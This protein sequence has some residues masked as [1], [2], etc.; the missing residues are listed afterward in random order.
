[1][2]T[3]LAHT[4]LLRAACRSGQHH[5][6]SRVGRC[7]WGEYCCTFVYTLGCHFRKH[8]RRRPTR[9]HGTRSRATAV[10][11]PLQYSFIHL[12]LHNHDADDEGIHRRLFLVPQC[13][14][15]LMTW[16]QH[17]VVEIGIGVQGSLTAS[18]SLSLRRGGVLRPFVFVPKSFLTMDGRHPAS[19]SRS[20][21]SSRRNTATPSGSRALWCPMTIP[22]FSSPMPA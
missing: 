13:A 8:D 6:S 10:R 7:R 22:P 17:V 3:Q 5:A 18:V 1:M 9:E 19:V 2:Y 15:C 12:C 20:S 21:R 11:R 14:P 16:W 4:K